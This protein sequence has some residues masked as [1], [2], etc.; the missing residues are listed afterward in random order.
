MITFAGGKSNVAGYKDGPSEDAKFSNDYQS[1]LISNV[2]GSS[3]LENRGQTIAKM[4]MRSNINL[5]AQVPHHLQLRTVNSSALCLCSIS[6]IVTCDVCKQEVQNLP[7]TLFKISNPQTVT[8]QPLNA[9]EPQQREEAKESID[10][11]EDDKVTNYLNQS[12]VQE[13]LHAKLVG[14]RKWDVCSK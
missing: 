8:R 12:D 7:V 13:E 1:N 9:L 2:G 4:Q 6:E 14:V 11:C 10:V 3:G 5:H